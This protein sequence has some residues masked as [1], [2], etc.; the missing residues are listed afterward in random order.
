M[1]PE[2]QFCYLLGMIVGKGTIV[3]KDSGNTQFIIEVPHK[4]LRINGKEAAVYVQASVLN[5]KT[6]LD[7]FISENIEV[8]TE[9]HRTLLY[10]TK[11]DSDIVTIGILKMLGNMPTYKS[12]RIPQE[13]FFYPN[14]LIK[15][16]LKGFADVTAH[17]RSSNAAYGDPS[18]NRVYIEIPDNWMLVVDVANLL[19]KIDIPVQDIDWAHPNFRDSNLQ[20]YNQGNHY[21][22]K[23]EHQIKIYAEEFYPVGFIIKHKEQRLKELANENEIEWNKRNHRNGATLKGAHH[24]FYWETVGNIRVRPPHPMENDASIPEQIRGKHF[25]SWKEIARELGYV[26]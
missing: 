21:F 19:K 24:R 4:N 12:M 26:K 5:I 17:I 10:F 15:E 9:E 11:K 14:S 1:L 3:R 2:P 6:I 23:K 8:S 7:P 13:L 25:N 20:K 22:W 16:F 18:G